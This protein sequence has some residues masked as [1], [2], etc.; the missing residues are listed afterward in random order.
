MPGKTPRGN[1]KEPVE[2]GGIRN[3]K[4]DAAL[5]GKKKAGKAG[6][7][8]TVVVAP[9]KG[10][11][12]GEDGDVAMADD[13]ASAEEEDVVKVDPVVQTTAG[14]FSS[15]SGGAYHGSIASCHHRTNFLGSPRC[16]S[17]YND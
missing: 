7:D 15:S 1:G 16:P 14:T 12:Q 4:D 11:K 17:V 10:K 13:D 5:K 6:E 2:N 9:S 3:N 8:A